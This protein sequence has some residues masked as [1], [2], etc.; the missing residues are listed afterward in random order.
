MI[1]MPNKHRS[2]LALSLI[3]AATFGAQFALAVGMPPL[4]Q[5]ALAIRPMACS[6]EGQ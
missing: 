2:L 3:L 5:E 6:F 4:V 1:R